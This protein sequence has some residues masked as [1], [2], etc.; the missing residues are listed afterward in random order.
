[1]FN[2]RADP[3]DTYTMGYRMISFLAVYLPQHPEYNIPEAAGMRGESRYEL[4]QLHRCL[5]HVALQ[6]DEDQLNRFIADDFEPIVD[7]VSDSESED[8]SLEEGNDFQA[9]PQQQQT[10]NWEPFANWGAESQHKPA[11]SPTVDTAGTESMEQYELSSDESDKELSQPQIQLQYSQ[12]Y[13]DDDEGD[14]NDYQSP[15]RFHLVEF[16]L[17]SDFLERIANEDVKYETDSE[18]MDSWAQDFDSEAPSE[19]SGGVTYDPARLVMRALPNRY[20]RGMESP[21]KEERARTSMDS[22]KAAVESLIDERS[23]NESTFDSVIDDFLNGSSDDDD[24]DEPGPIA[25]RKAPLTPSGLENYPAPRPSPT[26]KENQADSLSPFVKPDVLKQDKWV[27]FDSDNRVH[28]VGFSSA[29]NARV[30]F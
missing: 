6:I 12:D 1:M 26:G 23:D 28:K 7:D 3:E 10:G 30:E 11:D 20:P 18:A 27:S 21:V 5:E 8:G 14:Y 19:S 29:W 24:D 13:Y 4:D 16:E 17:D 9:T 22:A 2:Q 15:S 25:Q